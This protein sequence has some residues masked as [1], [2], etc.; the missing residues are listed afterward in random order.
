MGQRCEEKAVLKTPPY[1]NKNK[2]TTKP[3]SRILCP[4]PDSYREGGYHLSGMLLT[5]H[6]VLPT[7]VLR[8]AAVKRT[9]IWHFSTQGLPLF[10]VTNA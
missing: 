6:L 7:H 1:F 5:Q 9:L 3:V 4:D 8:R 2:K 10:I